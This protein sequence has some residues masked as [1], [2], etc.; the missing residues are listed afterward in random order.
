MMKNVCFILSPGKCFSCTILCMYVCPI[1][2]VCMCDICVCNSAL[3]NMKIHFCA[4]S[5]RFGFLSSHSFRFL[6]L[7][8]FVAQRIPLNQFNRNV[9]FVEKKSLQKSER[10]FF[11][12]KVRMLHM[13][14][15]IRCC[16]CFIVDGYFVDCLLPFSP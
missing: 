14:V 16:M 2:G 3:K 11:E 12:L 6:L 9:L 8:P 10:K 4:F 1:V 13:Y 7:R 15:A 5:D